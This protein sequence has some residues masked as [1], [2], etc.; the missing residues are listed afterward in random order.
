MTL[1]KSHVTHCS[2]FVINC[3]G[4]AAIVCFLSGLSAGHELTQEKGSSHRRLPF[5]L[6]TSWRRRAFD[7]WA[8][9]NQAAPSPFPRSLRTTIR[10]NSPPLEQGAEQEN[11]FIFAPQ[12]I[13]GPSWKSWAGAV[14]TPPPPPGAMS[15]HAKLI[16][17]TFHYPRSTI[18]MV[19]LACGC[20]NQPG[21]YSLLWEASPGA[22]NTGSQQWLNLHIINS[23]SQSQQG[24]CDCRFWVIGM[25]LSCSYQTAN[26]CTTDKV[27][28]KSWGQ[29]TPWCHFLIT[30]VNLGKL[31]CV[32][33]QKRYVP[34]VQRVARLTPEML[35][36]SFI[37]NGWWHGSSS[38]VRHKHFSGSLKLWTVT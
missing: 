38:K 18:W 13:D 6:V 19:L 34:L 10:V 24:N 2:Y 7:R 1:I 27:P 17:E 22:A 3:N 28:A 30:D 4:N 36:A 21:A 23:E 35:F 26:R 29:T 20:H 32:W 33:V 5:A 31:N 11:D 16:I 37:M 14:N 8:A 12:L 9:D 15:H 25:D